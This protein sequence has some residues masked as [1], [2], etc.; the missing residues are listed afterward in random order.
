M[1]IKICNPGTEERE[2]FGKGACEG[3]EEKSERVIVRRSV[4]VGI[5][6]RLHLKGLQACGALHSSL[7][8]GEGR[9]G[10]P[11]AKAEIAGCRCILHS[12]REER[13]R[14]E[15]R[16]KSVCLPGLLVYTHTHTP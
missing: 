2:S 4:W 13:C 14:E 9:A 10:P 3:E 6:S 15:V 16:A 7:R 1:G 12:E 5:H 8:R 11:A